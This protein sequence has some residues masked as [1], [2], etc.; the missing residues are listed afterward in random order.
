MISI[1]KSFAN[2]SVCPIL[3]EPSCILETNCEDDLRKVDVI[4]VAENPGKDE[5]L[6]GRPLVGRAGKIFRKY[7]LKLQLNKLNYLL[8][9][10]VLCRTLNPDGTTGNPSDETIKLCKENCFNII[11]ICNPKLIVLMGASPL[12]AFGLGHGITSVHGRVFDWKGYKTLVTVHPSFILRKHGGWEIKFEEALASI[13][14]LLDIKHSKVKKTTKVS[15]GA[16]GIF[17]YSL[18]EHFYTKEYRLIDV[19]YLKS[20]KQVIYIFRNSKNEK[21]YHFVNDDY[22]C[23]QAPEGVEAK[24]IVSFDLLNQVHVKYEDASKLSTD[25]TYEGDINIT[26]KHASDYYHF[27]KEECP[28]IKDNIMFFDIEVDTGTERVFPH[29]SKAEYPINMMSIIYNEKQVCYV[30]DNKT[31]KIE[32]KENFELKT[33]DNE[34]N[35]LL[36]FIEDFKKLDPDFIAGWNSIA[37]DLWYIFNR[38]PKLDL[39][40]N[41][42]SVFSEFLVDG[43]KY[44]C[45]IIGSVAIDQEY[46]YRKFTFN[47]KENYKLGF[48]ANLELK[49][50]KV[51]LPLPFNEMYWKM[52]NKTIE[53]NINDTVLLKELEAKLKHI[54]LRN[55]LRTVCHTSFDGVSP[56]SLIDSLVT[57]YLRNKNLASKNASPPSG[58]DDYAGA[59]VFEPVPNI[60]NDV[61]DFDFKSLYPS[62]IITYNIGINNFVLKF[63]DYK[64][65]YDFTYNP[66]ALPEKIEIVY[67][68]TFENKD[69]TCT[70]EELLK[71]VKEYNLVHT[72]NGCFFKNHDDVKSV[73]SEVLEGL[74]SSR[75]EYKNKMYD[76][77]E[78]KNQIA[79][80]FYYTRQLVYKVLANTLYGVIANKIYRFFDVSLAEAVTLSGREVL[81]TA[82]IEADALMRSMAYEKSYKAPEPLSKYEMYS[83]KLDR[84][85]DFIIT[86]DTDSIFCC[87]EKF[88]KE[89]TV[90]NITKWCSQI[91]DFLNK[92]KIADVVKA[93]N[94][95]ERNNILGL[96]NELIITRGLFLAK[97]R[98]AVRVISKEGKAVDKIE[99]VGLEI[100]RSD[101][102]SM[103]KEFLK[104]L[105]ELLL[106]SEKISLRK[107]F[108]RIKEK[109]LDF[110]RLIKNGEK[111]IARPISFGKD[112]DDYKTVPQGVKAMTAWNK[113]MYN[114]HKTGAKGYLFHVT[115]IDY[116]SAPPELIENYE[117]FKTEGEKLEV[118][119]I[120]DDEPRLPNYFIINI[121]KM[122]DFSFTKRYELLLKPISEDNDLGQVLKF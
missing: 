115:G 86:G 43:K 96:K 102:P 111:C 40:P 28:K 60:Y 97:K 45:R 16:K 22:V 4:F 72:I 74:M 67:D 99:Y 35:L 65:G 113:L 79:E 119:A 13:Y 2:C 18:P 47:K 82:I 66:K 33:F 9:N 42:L 41:S 49:K 1:K 48:I 5:V 103:T 89:K 114:I 23:Y 106:K 61:V 11:D 20:K 117:K 84:S 15:H 8:T 91:Q 39:D 116:N 26:I 95:P 52:L 78:K 21:I 81:K 64:M 122:L 24:K 75:E 55:E 53:Y 120:P 27:N 94:V 104:E 121:N 109:E 14:D 29:P 83:D 19:Q 50:T 77:I 118:I 17:R 92:Q 85:H 37:F 34:K 100:K 80:D 90:E 63:K 44:L 31:E 54:S 88:E 108:D 25:I 62:L 68:P 101:Y 12:K 110:L 51:E 58:K 7:F 105:S 112:I 46:I 73:F 38:M 30:V 70:Y 87:F 6:Q 107:L 36:Q 56:S 32:P 10:V 57:S 93:H 3:S 69:M 98:Y 59:F 71:K 76:A